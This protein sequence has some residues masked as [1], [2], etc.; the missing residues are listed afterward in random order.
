M[1]HYANN[2]W[3]ECDAG[4]HIAEAEGDG[5]GRQGHDPRDRCVVNMRITDEGRQGLEQ[6]RSKVRNTLA[7]QRLRL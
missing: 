6:S 4:F 1:E 2:E 3:T 7:V 5:R